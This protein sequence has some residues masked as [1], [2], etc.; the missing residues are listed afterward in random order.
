M[1]VCEYCQTSNND[2]HKFCKECGNRLKAIISADP[3]DPS[4]SDTL[5]LE[6]LKGRA[7]I[8][9]TR[10]SFDQAIEELVRAIRLHPNVA[11]LH[12]QL[13]SVFYKTRKFENAVVELERAVSFD[14]SHFKALLMLGNIYGEEV[15][16]HEMAIRIYSMAVDLKPNYPDLRNN[17]GNAYRFTG[18]YEE[19]AEQFIKAIELNPRYARAMF[20]LGKAYSAMGNY[21]E[22]EKHYRRAIEVDGN[23]PKAHKNLGVAL[24]KLGRVAEARECFRASVDLDPAYVKAW[25]ALAIACNELGDVGSAKEHAEH[26]LR[27]R[28]ELESIE[29]VLNGTG[30]LS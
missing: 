20:N 23:H 29:N 6:G 5:D 11:E 30:V 14:R 19:A 15:R 22:A 26:A 10:G 21:V 9:S 1:Q 25:T 4:Q 24:M 18:K 7:F 16:N 2:D 28:P 8:Y 27:L 12:F 17:L 3:V 13:G